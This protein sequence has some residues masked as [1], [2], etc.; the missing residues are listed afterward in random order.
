MYGVEADTGL[1]GLIAQAPGGNRFL[2][3]ALRIRPQGS[4]LIGGPPQSGTLMPASTLGDQT[5]LPVISAGG[6]A[7][8]SDPARQ[9]GGWRQILDFHNSPAPWIL[10][11]ILLLYAWLHAGQRGR[12]PRPRS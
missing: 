5:A 11:M 8:E 1:G 7:V 9:V 3:A 10:G 2:P 4:A 6:G 12:G